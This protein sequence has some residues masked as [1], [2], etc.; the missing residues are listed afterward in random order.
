MRHLKGI[1]VKTASGTHNVQSIFAIPE[2][3][4]YLYSFWNRSGG[5]RCEF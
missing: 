4:Y 3:G 1:A 5:D 2:F